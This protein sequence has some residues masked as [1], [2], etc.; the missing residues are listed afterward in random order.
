MAPGYEHIRPPRWADA[1]LE[2]FCHPDI[3]E[4][5]QGDLHELFYKRV[6]RGTL[7]S[8]RRQYVWD[9]LLACRPANFRSLQFKIYPAMLRNYL[10]IALRNLLRDK[11]YA[12]INIL[13]LAIGIACFLVIYL[14][15]QDELS[16]D[17]HHANK[18]R[19]VR[20]V[21]DRIN[22]EGVKSESA[23][24]FA[25]LG[26]YLTQEF[27]FVE[28]VARLYRQEAQFNPQS[29]QDHQY[30]E[31]HFFFADSAFFDLFSYH[32]V[33]GNPENALSKPFSIVLTESSAHKY[34]GDQPAMGE[35][36]RYRGEEES[37]EFTVSGV[38]ANPV[39][40]SHLQFDLLGSFNSLDRIMPWYNNWW[41]PPM[42]TYVML[43][44]QQDLQKLAEALPG[45]P[46]KIMKEEAAKRRTYHLQELTDIHLRSHRENELS[47]NGDIAQVYLFGLIAFF[48]LLIACINF[49]NLATAA[50]VTRAKEI[51][52]RKTLGAR[53]MQLVQQFLGESFLL[54]ALAFVLALLL[55]KLTLPYFNALIGKSL[56]SDIFRQGPT[57]LMLAGLFVMIGLLAG[58]YPA[59]FLSS[60]RPVNVL[61]R[62]GM[63]LGGGTIQLRKGLVVFQF[64]ISSGL[65]IATLIMY[66]Q[67]NYMQSH[68]LGFD[69]E[70]VITLPLRDQQ[71]QINNES[72]KE[73]WLKRPGV[74]SVSASSGV[75]TTE[76]L[77]NFRVI[78]KNAP[79]DSIE[80]ST[81]T[82]DHDFA[83]TYGLQFIAG[84]DFSKDH[85]TDTREALI[86][87][88]S[89]AKKIGWENPIGQEMLVGYHLE[90]EEFKE[91][92]VIGIV[93]DFHYH[94]MRKNVEPIVMHILPRSYYN[95]YISIKIAGHDIPATLSHLEEDWTQFNPHRTFEFSFLDE[96]FAQLYAKES[97]LNALFLFFVILS[98]FIACL[99][100]F[101][102]ASLTCE[103]RTKEI[104]I[105]KVLGA[106]AL[107]IVWLISN[108]F[109]RLVLLAFALAVPISWFAIKRWLQNFAYQT[110]IHPGIFLL[111]G[112]LAFIIALATIS[113]HTMR[114]ATSN[115]VKALRYE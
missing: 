53:R 6:E 78:P 36:L 109:T 21:R 100:L 65:L 70:Q 26:P 29:D 69:K 33:E 19:V 13:G 49:M 8:A 93:K 66:D 4:E 92:R 87:N 59:F 83:E 27:A 10:K 96:T 115:P 22:K 91:G 90:E 39:H 20:V 2:W 72:L 112:G 16:Y 31:D 62:V 37:F 77:Y 102:L 85:L 28:K 34:F 80:M 64:V 48:I 61:K 107:N 111:A 56:S 46:E 67:I 12:V 32:F 101:A 40:N 41:Y 97:R 113:F 63:R 89:A 95:N 50:S 99:G 25:P 88:E 7:T 110:E 35:V 94:S 24:T 81:L 108:Q 73:L 79:Q 68:N 38:I 51:G 45:L 106:S 1:L 9:V 58:L 74:I 14:H 71:D 42:Y 86:L 55:I 30:I 44:E 3:V 15:I 75:P 18:E 17:Q 5:L 82:V 60:F 98:V 57:M 23:R 47:V 104:G 76:G 54:T 52:V 11:Q 114:L 105:R 43:G 84:R 103:Q